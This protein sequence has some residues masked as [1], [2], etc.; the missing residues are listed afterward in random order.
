[1][2]GAFLSFVLKLEGKRGET[3]E[4]VSLLSSQSLPLIC[5]SFYCQVLWSRDKTTRTKFDSTMNILDKK[6]TTMQIYLYLSFINKDLL[7]ERVQT[8]A[9]KGIPSCDTLQH[10][11]TCQGRG[12][13]NNLI[14][15][16][17][18]RV[19]RFHCL[20]METN[21]TVTL[22]ELPFLTAS[23]A[24]LSQA[25]WNLADTGSFGTSSAPGN[26]KT[27]HIPIDF[28]AKHSN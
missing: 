14:H 5:K 24:I 12:E 18:P 17:H 21:M 16:L 9:N 4:K 19:S 13:Q 3:G 22:S 15:P 7:Q 10:G 8:P 25:S 26:A 28:C 20:L 1:M 2:E 11:S 27:H 6:D 23:L